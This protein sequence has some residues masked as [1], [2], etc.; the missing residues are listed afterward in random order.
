[1]QLHNRWMRNQA[2]YLGQKVAELNTMDKP[3]DARDTYGRRFYKFSIF[4]AQTNTSAILFSANG[5]ER[6]LLT[7]C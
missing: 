5:W 6:S 2:F 1:M 7:S 3:L 4:G